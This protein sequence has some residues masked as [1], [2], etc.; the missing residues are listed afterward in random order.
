MVGGL[1]QAI[2]EEVTLWHSGKSV[3]HVHFRLGST[4][5]VLKSL[6]MTKGER[7]LSAARNLE[8]VK[9]R[10]GGA[11]WYGRSQRREQYTLDT[12]KRTYG[13]EGSRAVGRVLPYWCGN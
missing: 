6:M 4:G 10:G 7:V 8:G 12:H 11:G 2:S 13:D 1:V 5:C 3:G 9:W